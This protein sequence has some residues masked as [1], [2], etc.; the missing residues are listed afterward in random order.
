M[1]GTRTRGLG[2]KRTSGDHPNYSIIERGQNT[3]KSPGDL[4][5]VITQTPIKDHQLTLMW[6]TLGINNNKKK[7]QKPGWEIRLESQIKKNTQ[8]SPNNKKE[9][10]WNKRG[11]KEQ[12]TWEK[13]TVQLEI[14]QKI[15]AKEGRLK[16]YRQ[17][18]K[19]YRQNRTF[20]NNERKFYQQLGGSDTKTYQQPDAKETERFWTKIWKPKKHNENAEWINNITRELRE[21]KQNEDLATNKLSSK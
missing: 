21:T 9:R 6:K 5:L 12:A 19:Q 14:N 3:E 11:K 18:V 7:Q 17:R 13:T 15:L 16:R 20:Q 4:S 2:N 1:T 10:R 8:T